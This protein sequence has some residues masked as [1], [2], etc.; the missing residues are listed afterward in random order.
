[1][2]SLRKQAV[3]V[4]AVIGVVSGIIAIV[5]WLWPSSASWL[6][7]HGFVGWPLAILFLILFAWAAVNWYQ[8][9]Q[10]TAKIRA[11]IQQIVLEDRRLFGAFKQA[12]PKESHVLYWLRNRAEARS[13]QSSDIKPLSNFVGEWRSSNRH[14]VD[15]RL[16]QAF[17][18]F[19]DAAFDFLSYQG[20]HSQ[21]APRELQTDRDD[22]VY[23]V[24]DYED[25]SKEREVQ[26]GLGKRA[27]RILEAHNELYMLGSRLGL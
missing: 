11:T 16:E 25:R 15:S 6:N 7:G 1:M 17:K 5:S 8:G 13:Y 18:R 4:A 20:L 26:E 22:P 24:Y 14:F 27:D 10:E 23:F 3:Y 19:S 21:W 12:L 9:A 2:T